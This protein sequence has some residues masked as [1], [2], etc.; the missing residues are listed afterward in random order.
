MKTGNN[1]Y[2]GGKKIVQTKNDIK[3]SV[4][5]TYKQKWRDNM[6]NLIINPILRTYSKIKKNYHMEPYLNLVKKS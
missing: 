5:N 6:S 2:N 1:T 4:L 3:I